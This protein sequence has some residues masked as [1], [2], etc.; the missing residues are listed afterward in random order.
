LSETAQ[1]HIVLCLLQRG[2][3]AYNNA[4]PNG[5]ALGSLIESALPIHL[6]P[7]FTGWGLT[8]EET[9]MKL[10][11][12][13]IGAT[14]YTEYTAKAGETLKQIAKD[15]MHDE[16]HFAEIYRLNNSVPEIKPISATQAIAGWTLLVPP[17]PASVLTNHQAASKKLAEIK[18]AADKGT[19]TAE[20]YYA[21]R[22]LILSVL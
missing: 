3:L 17:V 4:S 8:T 2:A 13:H 19:I 11:T 5:C 6:M 10:N 12:R 7:G 9:L 20:D 16:S 18:D 15:Q 14:F 22:K 1:E 21:Q